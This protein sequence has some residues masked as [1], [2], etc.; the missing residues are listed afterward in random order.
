M[1]P[2]SFAEKLALAVLVLT[3]LPALVEPLAPPAVFDELMYHLP[4]AREVAQSGRLGVHEWL[5]YPGFPTTTTWSMPARCCSAT[6]CCR[7]C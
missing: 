5:R 6:T 4:Y 7:T 2:F 3:A 1:V